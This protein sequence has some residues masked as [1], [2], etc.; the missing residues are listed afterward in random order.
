MRRLSEEGEG[1]NAGDGRIGQ[2]REAEGLPALLPPITIPPVETFD[3]QQAL[4]YL[5]SFIDYSLQRTYSYSD[6]TFDLGRMHAFLALLGDPHK[7]YPIFHVAGTKGK[8]SVSAMLES[9]LREAGYRTGFYTSP[10]LIDFCERIRLAGEPI[11][12]ERLAA[13]VNGVRGQVEKVPGLT[14]FEISTALAFLFF[15]EEGADAVVAEVGLGGRLDATNVVTP[16]V[17]V[18]TSLSYDHTH[19]LGNTLAEIAREKAGIIKP[20]IPA[21]SAPQEGEALGVILDVCR[22]R[23]APLAL[24]GRDWHFAPRTHSLDG[25]SF[26]LWSA[27]DQER[28]DERLEKGDEVTWVPLRFDIPLLGY[29]QVINAATAITALMTARGRGLK[30]PEEAVREGLRNV[31][32]EGRFQI[33][34]RAPMVVVDSAHNR[35]SARRLRTAL[36]DYFPGRRVILLFGASEDKDIG[37]MLDEL[38]PRSARLIATRSTHPRAAPLEEIVARAREHGRPAEGR[39]DPAAALERALELTGPEDVLLVA[40]S[41]FVA[42]AVL[43]EWPAVSRRRN[44]SPSR[45]AASSRGSQETDVENEWTRIS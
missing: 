44:P 28:M 17:S 15:A 3:Y 29:H 33:L 26:F 7:R 37:G 42:G 20:G 25:Q 11:A 31:R 36:D 40:G 16:F 6:R 10:H 5:Y 22:E 14:T 30:I 32:W 19:L 27:R 41:L 8:G 38:L 12:H 18:I 1:K 2:S 43:A 45:A 13:L 24:V 9:V 23:N 4:D 21:V 34:S 35:D 39:E